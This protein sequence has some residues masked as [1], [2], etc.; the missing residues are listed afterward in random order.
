[1]RVENHSKWDAIVIGSGIGGMATASL[2]TRLKKK[3]VLV[4]ERHWVLGG[5]THEFTRQGKY[6]WDVGLHYV[7]GMEV[8]SQ[9]RRLMDFITGGAVTWNPLPE[10][11]EHF[12]FPGKKTVVMPRGEA[13]WTRLLC[14]KFPKDAHGI[15]AFFKDMKRAE[16]W[17]T[18]NLVTQVVPPFVGPLI[19]M[20]AKSKKA[21]ALSTTE[22]AL[23][24]RVKDPH[25]RAILSGFWGDYGLPP[26]KSALVQHAIVARHYFGGAWFPQGGASTIAPAVQAVLATTGGLMVPSAEVISVE[27]E[28]GKATGVSAL[29]GRGKERTPVTLHAPLIFSDAGVETTYRRLMPRH[30]PQAWQ[31]D[32]GGMAP[33]M[34]AVTL[35]LGL[36]DDPRKLGFH[37]EN[38]WISRSLDQDAVGDHH[39]QMMAGKPLGGYISFPSIKN[40]EAKG[41][42]AEIISFARAEEFK[43]WADTSWKKR[44]DEYEAVKKRIAEGLLDLVEEEFPGLRATVDYM[45]LS[46]PLTYTDFL[47]R[48]RGEFYGLPGTPE[49]FQLPW[50]KIKTP[51][52]GCYLTGSDVMCLGIMGAMMG[53]VAAA[54]VSMGP[55]GWPEVMKATK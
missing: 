27:V 26:S 40:P 36:K 7:G 33:G 35:F 42:T 51:V 55:S 1:M 5:Q 50:L 28:A 10:D 31:E 24:R 14:E 41:H 8:G 13:A 15:R 43:A 44:G 20:L 49:R 52:E 38:N 9:S 2:L 19:R 22:A 53:G 48:P 23:R 18:L 16:T 47:A 32:L 37:G 34:S 25:A 21:V 11:L 54:A 3:K 46:T 39:R 30:V 6:S 17:A 4:L 29:L 45:E 12:H